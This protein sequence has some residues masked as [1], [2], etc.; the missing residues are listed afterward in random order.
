M[1]TYVRALALSDRGNVNYVVY[2]KLGCH[3]LRG[4]DPLGESL[5]AQCYIYDYLISSHVTKQYIGRGYIPVA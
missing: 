1:D 3:S 4:C 5:E 2:A